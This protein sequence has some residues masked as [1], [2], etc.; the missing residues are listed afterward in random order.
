VNSSKTI[1]IIQLLILLNGSCCGVWV[2]GQDIRVTGEVHVSGTIRNIKSGG[3]SIQKENGESLNC[4]IQDK[5]EDAISISGV[6][7]RIPAQI[8]VSGS[9]PANLIEKGMI[10]QFQGSANQY[11]KTDGKVQQLTLLAD[12][13]TELNVDFLERPEPGEFGACAVIGRV[14]NLSRQKLQLQVPKSKWA[15]RE[16]IT[17]ELAEACML[18][19]DDDDLNLVVP[20][21]EVASAVIYE[22]SSGENV[23]KKIDVRLTATRDAMTTS[24]HDKLEQQFS[25]LP[26]EPVE[27]REL[28]SNNFVLYSDLSERNASILLSK[29]ET[30]HRLIGGYFGKRPRI[31]IE[32]FV[33]SDIQKWKNQELHPSGV[34][35]ILE[36]A[37]V[38]LTVRK[39][40]SNEAKAIVYS[41]DKHGVCQHE[42]VHAFCAQAFGSTGPVWYSEGMA[43]MGQYWKPGELAV[44]ID[45]VVID[46]LTHAK[47]KKMVEIVAAGQITGD[48]WQAYAWRWALCHLLASNPNYS[49]RFKKLG[50]EM[51]S[52]GKDSFENAFGSV[53]DNISFEYDQFVRNFGNGYRVDLCAWNW[54]LKAANLSSTGRSK[55][56]VKAQSGWQPTRLETREGVSYEYVAQG[57][58]NISFAD[59]AIS[60]DGNEAGKGKLIGMIL[61]DFKIEGTFELGVRGTFVAPVKG[62]LYLRCDDSWTELADNEGEITVHLRRTPNNAEADEEDVD[63]QE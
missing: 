62:Q 3:V 61:H 49:R 5:D 31:P 2:A 60:A 29:L 11:G 9:L 44:N 32:C 54:N 45:P 26:D 24:Y 14:I 34:E 35:K 4:K 18:Q 25:D 58:W 52:G 10:V 56:V 43:E 57:E 36:P 8:S 40:G 12:T 33:V 20:G 7:I 37:G 42:A 48:S 21:D 19:I 46:Y 30:M 17:F 28:R 51:M 23:V 6:P 39:I 41:C 38:T 15:K 53:A 1:T 13:T 22:M 55:T 16:R 59:D 27:P 50:L 63:E 47:P